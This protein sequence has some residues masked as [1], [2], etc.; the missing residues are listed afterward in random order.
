MIISIIKLCILSSVS[1]MN[2]QNAFRS[3]NF[4]FGAYTRDAKFQFFCNEAHIKVHLS[5]NYTSVF[6]P[7]RCKLPYKGAYLRSVVQAS[8]RPD[9]FP[10]CT[11]FPAHTPAL[12]A[13]RR[14]HAFGRACVSRAHAEPHRPDITCVA[15]LRAGMD[16]APS[17]F[18]CASNMQHS[19]YF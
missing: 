18:P 5:I 10:R 17:R 9:G 16:R 8:G 1:S 11:S 3:S 2:Y 4:S 13:L 7:K 19:I 14:Q 6:L 12:H 15:R